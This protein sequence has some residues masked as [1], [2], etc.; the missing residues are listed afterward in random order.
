MLNNQLKGQSMFK[1]DER[2]RVQVK[3][4]GK[5]AKAKPKVTVWDHYK[6]NTLEGLATAITEANGR[7]GTENSAQ[8]PYESGKASTMWRIVG[9]QNGGV[10]ETVRI[11][12]KVGNRN[13]LPIFPVYKRLKVDGEWIEQK[14]ADAGADEYQVH[15]SAVTKNLRRLESMVKSMKLGDGDLGDMFHAEALALS[16]K[17]RKNS[18]EN[19]K[20]RYDKD[21]D[22]FITISTG[23]CAPFS[24]SEKKGG[25]A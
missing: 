14:V 9:E 20:V 12:L 8:V 4:G 23:E 5:K 16:K 6:K 10:D 2:D 21:S 13:K 7:F 1:A 24:K 22:M 17:A 19:K 25:I 18:I 15:C 3:Q 11:S